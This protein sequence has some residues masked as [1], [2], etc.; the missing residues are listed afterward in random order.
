MN[1]IDI[2]QTLTLLLHIAITN[3]CEPF[4]QSEGFAALSLK[5]LSRTV[6]RT[7][8]TKPAVIEISTIAPS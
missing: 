3:A 1:V 7:I 6:P 4:A 5:C 8:P 2:V